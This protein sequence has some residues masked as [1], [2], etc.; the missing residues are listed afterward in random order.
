MTPVTCRDT[1]IIYLVM[2]NRCSS[3]YV[4]KTQNSLRDRHYG[5]R[6]EIDTQS[7]LLGKH[8]GE[9]CGINSWRI[10]IIDKCQTKDLKSR[11][12]YWMHELNLKQ[13]V[14]Q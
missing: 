2:C 7:S 14:K 12:G 5:H 6:R 11:E 3:Q 8:F 9:V 4:G 1:E 13:S 10:Q